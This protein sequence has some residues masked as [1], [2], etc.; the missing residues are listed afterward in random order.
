VRAFG[1]K[2][3]LSVANLMEAT[4]FHAS[5]LLP[6]AISAQTVYIQSTCKL[7]DLTAFV[8]VALAFSVFHNFAITKSFLFRIIF[9]CV[10]SAH[11][12]N[13]HQYH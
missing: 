12:E 8:S 9:V 1:S 6:S 4:S 2:K 3:S 7:R 13:K 5:R 11:P 10:W